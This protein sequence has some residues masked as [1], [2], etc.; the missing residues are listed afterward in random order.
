MKLNICDE[1]LEECAEVCSGYADAP[2][3]KYEW[4]EYIKF[5]LRQYHELE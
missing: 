1:L 3:N 5:I 2:E 4:E